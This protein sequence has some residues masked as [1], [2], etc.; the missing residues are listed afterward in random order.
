MTLPCSSGSQYAMLLEDLAF[1]LQIQYPFA[2]IH[3]QATKNNLLL[4]FQTGVWLA[5]V[6]S[7]MLNKIAFWFDPTEL[8]FY[9]YHFLD[10]VPCGQKC[11]VW[12]KK[13]V[14]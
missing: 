2:P 3:P 5:S 12:G 9:S 10:C 4:D 11:A 7:I 6:V 8:F 1:I 14:F 13:K